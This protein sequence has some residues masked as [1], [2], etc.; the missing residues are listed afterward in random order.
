MHQLNVRD[1]DICNTITHI[2]TCVI[3]STPSR[4]LVAL[5]VPSLI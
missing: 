4:L 5:K 1:K 3:F 2:I